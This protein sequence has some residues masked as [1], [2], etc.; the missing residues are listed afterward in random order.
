MKGAR[1]WSV[2]LGRLLDG[3]KTRRRVFWFL[4]FQ[5]ANQSPAATPHELRRRVSSPLPFCAARNF[6][7]VTALKRRRQFWHGQ[8]GQI[9]PLVALFLPVAILLFGLVVDIGLLFAT[10][11]VMIAAADLGA[12]GGVQDVD[13][14]RLSRGE[15]WLDGERA[16]RD[17]Y[18]LTEVNLTQNQVLGQ[19]KEIRVEVLNASLEHPLSHPFTGRTV[20]DPTV[21]VRITAVVRLPFLNPF[22]GETPLVVHADASVLEKR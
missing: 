8:Y 6:G 4:P 21:A 18:G 14:D 16:R 20:T 12:L 10:R 2:E 11:Q 5:L 13:L 7:E 1:I 15:I 17:A 3:S 22:L 9:L 19:I